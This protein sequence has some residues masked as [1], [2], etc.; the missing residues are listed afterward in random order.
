MIINNVV[1]SEVS[2]SDIKVFIQNS[3]NLYTNYFHHMIKTHIW[4]GLSSVIV[5]IKL[6]LEVK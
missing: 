2:F 3:D 4:W 1:K 6:I 5:D